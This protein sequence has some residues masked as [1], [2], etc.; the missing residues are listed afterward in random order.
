MMTIR[1]HIGACLVGALCLAACSGGKSLE[2][3]V[4]PS[5]SAP[6]SSLATELPT[7]S[8]SP[9]TAATRGVTVST[10]TT[11]RSFGSPPT[12][13]SARPAGVFVNDRPEPVLG[14][15][16]G[17]HFYVVT[18]TQIFVVD[19]D[20]GAITETSIPV[21][22][23]SYGARAFYGQIYAVDNGL[24]LETNTLVLVDATMKVPPRPIPDVTGISF[25]GSAPDR[26]WSWSS[27][28]N[29]Y[30]ELAA[31]GTR[32]RALTFVAPRATGVIGNDLVTSAAGRIFLVDITSGASREWAVGELTNVGGGWIV[33]R[34]CT[35]HLQCRSYAGNAVN[36][37]L[38]SLEPTSSLCG[39]PFEGYHEFC[40]GSF[41]ANGRFYL[42]SD[43]T[44]RTGSIDPTVFDLEFGGK[45]RPVWP[46]T[47][48]L[49]NAGDYYGLMFS[50]DGQWLFGMESSGRIAAV[51][52]ESGKLLEFDVVEP[53]DRTFGAFAIG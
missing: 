15:K 38:R 42:A 37:K 28:A 49:I 51:H 16:T 48:Q 26:V 12:T 25:R 30:V 45:T 10:T 43:A 1:A 24:F 44:A 23:R 33:W 52:L 50:P 20:T 2:R 21:S 31:D 3:T 35:E 8:A 5:T 17:W 41:S 53:R 47:R 18:G 40:D 14:A 4:A 36:P 19:L 9:T 11:T 7:T 27:G 22:S 6:T 13:L 46:V 34:E 39:E 29:N 32:T